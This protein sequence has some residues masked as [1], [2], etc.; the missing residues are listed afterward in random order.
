MRWIRISLLCV[1]ALIVAIAIFVVLLFTMDLGRFKSQAEALVSSELGRRLQIE[2]PFHASLG[3][4]IHL[5]AEDIRL[6]NPDWVTERSLVRVHKLD[7]SLNTW[8]L[9]TGR[10]LIHNIELDNIA[11]HL[12]QD[13]TGLNNW[14]LFESDPAA[15]T[16]AR[17]STLDLL[18]QQARIRDL[19]ITYVD[20]ARG[21]PIRFQ[22]SA[23]DQVQL[24]SGDLQFGLDGDINGTP[25]TLDGTA[26]S[27]ADLIAA[28]PVHYDLRAVIG[29]IIINSNA[30]IDNLAEPGKPVGHLEI[31]GPNA[32]Y[33]TDVFGIAPVTRGPLNLVAKMEPVADN[34]SLTIQGEFGEFEI[35]VA[36]T[37]SDLQDLDE[38]DIDFSAAGPNAATFGELTGLDNI[39]ADPYSIRGTVRRKGSSIVAENVAIEIGEMEFDLSA[40]IAEFPGIDGSVVSLTLIGPDFGR[41]N[42]LLGLPG[43]LTGPFSLTAN[44]SQSPDGSE[45]VDIIAKARDIQFRINGMVSTA[46]D[47]VGTEIALSFEGDDLSVITGALDI[48]NGPRIPFDVSAGI[49]RSNLGFAVEEGIATLGDDVIR[50]DGLV[51]IKPL[52]SNTD[53]KFELSGPNLARALEM[54]G[55]ELENLPPGSY[56]A[57]GRI[58]LKDEYFDLDDITA[59]LGS[60]RA[61]LSGRLG[62]LEDLQGTDIDIAI[63]GDSLAGLAPETGE[64]TFADMP[65]N[66]AGNVR[67][68]KDALNIRNLKMRIGAGELK[69]D[70]S[71]GMTPM[72]SSGSI[73]IEAQGPDV[74]EWLP[75]FADYI[76]ANAAFDLTSAVHWQDT[77]VIVDQLSLQLGKGRLIVNGEVDVVTDF[78]RTDL[79]IDARI[80]SLSNLGRIAGTDLPDEPLTLSAHLV[81][82]GKT[83]RLEDL[84]VKSGKSDLS[85]SATYDSQGDIPL[86]DVDL[87][88][89]Y[90]NVKPFLP[91]QADSGTSESAPPPADESRVI[92]D[93]PIPMELLQQLNARVDISIGEL[94]LRETTVNDVLLDGSLQSGALR[95]DKFGVAG[96]RGTLAGNLEILPT[97]E[98]AQVSAIVDGT[99]L[100]LGLTPSRPDAVDTLPIY[101]FQLK[102]AASGATVRDLAASLDGTLRLVGGSG[103][104]KNMPGWFARD[105]VTEVADK[106]NPFT[107]KEG[108]AQIQCFAVLLRSVAGQ[109]D[110]VPALVLQT[111]KLNVI[112]VAYVD[113]GT[114]KIDVKLETAPRK[115][116]GVGIADFVTPYIMVGGTMAKPVLAFDAEEAVKRGIVTAATLGT[117]W[118]AKKVKKRYFSPKDPCGKAVTEADEEMRQIRGE[119]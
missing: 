39:P 21:S 15:E 69:S 35:D 43:K 60:T 67:V 14:T 31:S 106:V 24:E 118:I 32:E 100:T 87:T 86:V 65:F 96:Q 77:H 45:L 22:A 47:F 5:V 64:F 66:V 61:R 78:S 56:E 46:P 42:K 4:E 119:Q 93:T 3:E 6:D 70:M 16:D 26:G 29:E 8:A 40:N 83:L 52:E 18:I 12:E 109:I 79:N 38:V 7:V 44:L 28:G 27:F 84:R 9:I 57:A 101:D 54:A 74:A 2:G 10:I 48:P 34:T 73:E 112:S 110:G 113:L 13:G 25:V 98:G 55:V 20:P 76:P 92:P 105:F 91:K 114:E 62:D 108:F 111:D 11:I 59:R 63:E 103:R 49:S 97:V 116:I 80:A 99:R 58:R 71:I 82:A 102:L 1:G 72:L 75:S 95:I 115:G 94:V 68:A 50:V 85:G 81:G 53:I 19:T 117:S 107:K 41:F 104:I 37:F 89:K 88:S 36:G 23:I 30:Q 33:L 17:Q 90:L 51:G